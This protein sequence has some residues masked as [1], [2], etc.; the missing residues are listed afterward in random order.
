MAWCWFGGWG[1][2]LE[3]GGDVLVEGLVV[4]VDAVGVDGEQDVDAVPGAK[5]P[6]RAGVAPGSSACSNCG[7]GSGTSARSGVSG[8][9]P[10]WRRRTPGRSRSGVPGT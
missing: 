4:A 3:G 2:G 7:T 8:S 9:S 5:W 10:T 6:S 1:C